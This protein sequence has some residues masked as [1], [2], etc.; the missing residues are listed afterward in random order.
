MDYNWSQFIMEWEKPYQDVKNILRYLN[1]YPFLASNLKIDDLNTPEELDSHQKDWLWLLSQYEGMEKAFFKP[2]WIPVSKSSLDLFIDLSV[3]GYP[4]FESEYIFVAPYCYFKNF[5]FHNIRD[6]LVIN[7]TCF[8]F[9]EF[10]HQRLQKAL[11]QAEE[12]FRE[13]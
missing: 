8:N 9:E 2:W 7:D 11:D 1:T 3:P 10:H 4:L 12:F 6:L 5:L 13:V